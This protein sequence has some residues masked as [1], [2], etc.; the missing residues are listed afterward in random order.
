[1]MVHYF[2]SIREQLGVD[3]EEIRE[4]F[5]K[6]SSLIEHLSQRGGSWQKLLSDEQTLVA[7]DK[8]MATKDTALGNNSEVAFFPF[9]TGG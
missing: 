9:M 8:S 6:V 1:M 3:N 4:S 2:A 5:T 7:V